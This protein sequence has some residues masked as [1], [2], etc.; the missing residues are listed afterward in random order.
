MVAQTRQD[1]TY[2][3]VNQN[4]EDILRSQMMKA[5]VGDQNECLKFFDPLTFIITFYL[6]RVIRLI[7]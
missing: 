6:V 7:R 5:V 3:R 4:D 2:M 1:R